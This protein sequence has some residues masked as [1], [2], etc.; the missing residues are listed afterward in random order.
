MLHFFRS[1]RTERIQKKE[2]MPS[3]FHI[4]TSHIN[5]TR[6]HWHIPKERKKE[7]C[8]NCQCN[9]NPY[10]SRHN[11]SIGMHHNLLFCYFTTDAIIS[12]QPLLCSRKFFKH[13]GII[14]SLIVILTKNNLESFH[15]RFGIHL[16]V[17]KRFSTPKLQTISVQSC[18]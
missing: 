3:T 13:E 11:E 8:A 4:D 14:G 7:L 12:L 5:S 15:P 9:Q 6:T 2:S 18:K 17:S 10:A 1:P 16:S